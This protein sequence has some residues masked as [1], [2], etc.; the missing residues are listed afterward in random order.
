[1]ANAT[2]ALNS[3]TASSREPLMGDESSMRPNVADATLRVFSGD[4]LELAVLFFEGTEELGRLFDFTVHTQVDDATSEQL[5]ECNIVGHDAMLSIF[6]GDGSVRRIRS[7][8]AGCEFTGMGHGQCY[9]AIRLRPP[10]WL[11]TQRV[12]SR[13]FQTKRTEEIIRAILKDHHLEHIGL[14]FALAETYEPRDYCVQ[15]GE[16]DW[17][18]VSRLM[19]EDGMCCFYREKDGLAHL[20]FTDGPH[21]HADVEFGR[22]VTFRAPFGSELKPNS[23]Y[24]FHFGRSIRPGRVT[25]TD[26]KPRKPR[27]PLTVSEARHSLERESNLEVFVFPGEYRDG[28]L[29]RRLTQIRLQE[30]RADG[31]VGGGK[32]NRPDL[33]PGHRFALHDH[34]LSRLNREYLLTHVRHVGYTPMGSEQGFSADGR[35]LA[36][37]SIPPSYSNEFTA[38]PFEHKFR[39]KRVTPRPRMNG[40]QTARV[41]GRENEEIHTDEYGRVKVRFHWDRDAMLS[42]DGRKSSDSS[43]W[44]R[45]SQPWA[46]AGYGGITIPRIGQ[47]VIVDFLDGDPDQPII[48]GRV[49][50]GEAQAPQSM[51]APT[52]ATASGGKP[53]ASMTERKQTLPE[54]A[55]RTSIRSNSLKPGSGANE[56]TLDDDGGKELFHVNATKDAVRTVGNDDVT[57]VA[58]DREISVG[59]NLDEYVKSNRDRHVG[60]DETVTVDANQKV[61]VK[62]NQDITVGANRSVTVKGNEAHTVNMCRAQQVMISE[63]VLTGVS[64]T[65]ETG[66]AH[67]ET[68]GLLHILAVGLQRLNLVGGY[69]TLI[70]GKDKS[71]TIN[72]NLSSE[73]GGEA[74][75]KV[76]SKLVIECPDITLAAGGNFIRL[77][78]GGIT[79]KGAPVKINCAGAAPGKLSNANAA[80]PPA[81]KGG[82]ASGS[83]AGSAGGAAGTGAAGGGGLGGAIKDALKDLGVEIPDFDGILSLLDIPA[84]S[85]LAQILGKIGDILPKIPGLDPK[86]ADLFKNMLN[87]GVPSFEDIAGIVRDRLPKDAQKYF[88]AVLEA[89]KKANN[90]PMKLPGKPTTPA[91]P[92]TAGTSGGGSGNAG[93]TAGAS[94]SSAGGGASAGTASG[95]TGDSAPE[96]SYFNPPV[97]GA[98][99]A[100]EFDPAAAASAATAAAGTSPGGNCGTAVRAALQAGGI[101]VQPTNSAKDFGPNLEAAGFEAVPATEGSY[102]PQVGDVVVFQ[103]T[104][105]HP[106]GHVQIYNGSHFVSDFVQNDPF[107]PSSSPTSAWKTN[108]PSFTVYRHPAS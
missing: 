50:N 23:V 2:N 7:V 67:V 70:V 94:N 65:V 29:G 76:G 11:L 41:V 60:A 42:H 13:I 46:G 25:Q 87:N 45:V 100:P 82:G 75:L 30:A 71:E 78:A 92:G 97:S 40:P 43:C 74:G 72:G 44:I 38:I 57:T 32:S 99:P 6:A 102:V 20:Q 37:R 8:I 21:G 108:K 3:H 85:P 86:L 15:Y 64:K 24:A 66:L 51:A 61:T 49:Y 107:W 48:T 35:E 19:E 80:A 101:T 104:T 93:P 83:G 56:I 5:T 36:A 31:D 96:M 1:M 68:V 63:N 95:T 18:F 54:A 47:E 39:L 26:Y 34:P 84:D 12:N 88:D 69:D 73:V 81:S 62:A 89:M 22:D 33:A 79:I 27:E 53:I 98:T 4:A 9:Y 52:R 28:K 58:R 55:T 106:H 16:S 77:H 17:D 14:S 105:G 91:L 59:S 10:A 90:P 103:N